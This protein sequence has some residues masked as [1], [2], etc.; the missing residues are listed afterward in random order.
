MLRQLASRAPSLRRTAL[1]NS[2]AFFRSAS[3]D[4]ASNN[5][6]DEDFLGA[7]NDGN[8]AFLHRG[9]WLSCPPI[10]D[11]EKEKA[12]M[13][14]IDYTLKTVQHNIPGDSSGRIYGPDRKVVL[15]VKF[16]PPPLHN[17]AVPLNFE[18]L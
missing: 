13:R 15:T 12:G 10:V 8:S 1:N 6:N 3:T 16:P 14:R 2:I 18:R 5:S 7:D 11:P 9:P 4:I 17:V